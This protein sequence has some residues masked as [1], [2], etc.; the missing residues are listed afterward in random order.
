M[1]LKDIINIMSIIHGKKTPCD[2]PEILD[3]EYYSKSK[4]TNI[5]YGD[6]DLI[7]FLRVTNNSNS[8]ELY[9]ELVTAKS[10]ILRLEKKLEKINNIL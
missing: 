7:H 1:K 2:I 3:E 6:M 4:D 8:K 10:K 5:K 9:D